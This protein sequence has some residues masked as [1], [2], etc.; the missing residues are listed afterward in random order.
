M[1]W[2]YQQ[3]CFTKLYGDAGNYILTNKHTMIKRCPNNSSTL[4]A[5]CVTTDYVIPLRETMHEYQLRKQPKL[6]SLNLLNWPT[7]N[8]NNHMQ[9]PNHPLSIY[10]LTPMDPRL[11]STLRLETPHLLSPNHCYAPRESN[12]NVPPNQHVLFWDV[13]YRAYRA[14]PSAGTTTN[15]PR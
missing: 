12:D 6:Q 15:Y 4:Y 14:T 5:N 11:K 9:P 10:Q 7:S 2:N 8:I 1:T 13:D 3:I